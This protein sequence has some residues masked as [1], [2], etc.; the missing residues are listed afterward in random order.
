MHGLLDKNFVSDLQQ[1]GTF[2]EMSFSREYE[3]VWTGTAEDSFFDADLFDKYRVIQYAEEEYSIKNSKS[4]YI[5]SVD[6]G[7]I[8]DRTIISVVKSVPQSNGGSMNYLVN[9]IPIVAEHFEYQSIQIKKTCEK[10]RASKL[11]IDGNG[12]GVGLID[13]LL[14]PNIDTEEGLE[15]PP[16]GVEYLTDE[17]ERLYRR[18]EVPGMK[19]E[20]IWILKANSQIN[21]DMHVNVLSQISSGKVRFLIDHQAAKMRLLSTKKGQ[22]MSTEKRSEYLAPYTNTSILKEE[23]SNLRAK[24]DSEGKVALEKVNRKITKDRFSSFEMALY[25]I[26]L[27]D[28]KSKQTKLNLSQFIIGTKASNLNKVRRRRII[29]TRRDHR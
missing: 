24:R 28:D 13:Y 21:N 27:Q 29:T 10:Y 17:Q 6:V 18:F 3:S 23:M 2:N 20:M 12:L 8:N 26:K 16:Y 14:K 11:I 4:Y 1:D 22:D 25:Y 19:K 7:R 5:V 15:Y 9:I